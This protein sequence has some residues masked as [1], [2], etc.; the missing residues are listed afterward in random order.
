MINRLVAI[1]LCVFSM[2]GAPSV[3]AHKASDSYLTVTVSETGVSGQWDIALRDLDYALG[4]DA[5]ENSEITWGEVKA[6]H[7]EIAA[8]SL[9]RLGVSADGAACPLKVTGQLI[10]DH[11]DGAY[12]VL[13]FDAACS[14]SPRSLELSYKLFFDID[15][16][17]RGLLRLQF[18]DQ[19]QTTIFSPDTTKKSFD[20]GERGGT[21][22]QFLVYT[23]EGIWHIWVGFDHVLFLVSL[24]LPAVL[25]WSGKTWQPAPRF[26]GAFLEVLKIVTAFTLAHSI[27]L[28]L[29]ALEVVSLPSRLV[30]S[31]IALSVV[32]AALNNLY[33]M[34]RARRWVGA[35]GFGLVHGFGFA[36]VLVDLG[37]PKWALL[38]ALL[39]FNVGVEIGQAVIVS[40]VLPVTFALRGTRFY[41][42]G[43]FIGGSWLIVAIASLWF[44]E[45][46]L[47]LRII[48]R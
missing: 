21:F 31:L 24:L 46:A 43:V 18:G 35:F 8:Y 44:L 19:T 37:L 33:P 11:T 13:R 32:L 26:G 27:T 14:A 10:D 17:H 48:T 9:A 28:T 22:H 3:S 34:V 16:Q 4:L 2:L 25:V 41:Q 40:V 1:F 39:G 7:Q 20:L 29:A 6:K 30:E 42:R 45:R 47:N 38:A 15:P 23:K 36:S 12:T 5:D